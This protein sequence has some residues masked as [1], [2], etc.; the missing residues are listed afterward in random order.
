M[1]W[2]V[3]PADPDSFRPAKDPV[4]TFSER[5]RAAT[6][7]QRIEDDSW[8]DSARFSERLVDDMAR[9][10]GLSFDPKQHRNVGAKRDFLFGEIA[11]A[12][13]MSADAWPDLP[14]NTDEFNQR[15]LDLQKADH[16]A[17]QQVL[18]NA[19]AGSW[20]AEV[21]GRTWGG[22]TDASSVATLPLGAAGGARIGATILAEGAAAA[23]GEAM[24]ADQRREQA[25]RLGLPQPSVVSDVA[26]AA[27]TGAV[28]GGVIGGAG[29]LIGRGID[30][31]AAGRRKAAGDAASAES[32]GVSTEELAEARIAGLSP[33]RQEA[34]LAATRHAMENGYDIP[35]PPGPHG[36]NEAAT[37]RAIIGAESGGTRDPARA[38]NPNSSA[39]GLGQF[40]TDTWFETLSRHR[41]DLTQGKDKYQVAPL[42]DDPALNAEMTRLH[43]RDNAEHLQRNGIST[44]PGE[45]YLAHF[46]GRGGAVRAL[47]APLNTPISSLMTRREIAA[48]AGIRH[49]GK[50]FAQF[51][52]GDL[53]DWARHKMRSA[54]DPNASTDMPQWDGYT[55]SRG[56]TGSGQVTAGDNFRLDAD[57]EVVDARLLTRASG[58]YQPRDRGR[59]SSD[60]WVADTAAR[61]DP[62]QLMPAPTA[63]RGTPLVGPDGMIESG[64]GRFS[65]I[66]RAYDRHPDR[67][68]A[69][70]QQIEAA[71]YTIPEGVERPVLIAR[72]RTELDDAQRQALTV[73]AQDSGVAR[74]TPTEI[75]QTSSRAMTAQRLAGFVPTARIADPDNQGFVRQILSALPR[76]ERNALLDKAGALNAEGERR[77]R[78][79]FFARAWDDPDLVSRYAEAEDAGDL[80]S[81]MDALEDA[82]PEW[83][84]LRAEIEAGNV[85]AEFDITGHVLEAMRLIGRARSEAAAGRGQMARIL[86]DILDEIDLLDGALS[87]LTVRLV[88]KFWRDGRAAPASEVG[89]FLSRYAAEARKAGRTGDLLGISPTDALRTIDDK[90]FGDLPQEFGRVRGHPAPTV[91]DAAMPEDAYAKGADSPEAIDADQVAAEEMAAD[92][93]AARGE[94]SDMTW[95]ADPNGPEITARDLLDDIGDDI[96]LAEVLR[97]CNAGAAA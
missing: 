59:I 50:S 29:Q 6:R 64:N 87:P 43:M 39:R 13:D 91:Q 38:Q 82:A 58:P 10:M 24:I 15:A 88:Q 63:D 83:A 37:L 92:L 84:T 45:I 68:A 16:A 48:N 81:L 95:R 69:Y 7:M 96:E 67:A 71:G 27:A 75:A 66:E 14:T 18:Q 31:R 49:R 25:D 8:G 44:G 80:K 9:Q 94:Y 79:A 85:R 74:M 41:P 46:M 56:Y 26:G 1:N 36:Y 55:T 33:G 53:A 52:A 89:S 90:T 73:D 12:R 78:Q 61:L 70:R 97:L 22:L 42:R 3:K 20:G 72:R 65:A 11:R 86:A 32:L 19:P 34:A 76:S 93:E 2:F 21:L 54:Y 5:R 17:N 77:L 57:Y 23:A 28:L 60:A 35:A 30:A 4:P 47:R 51:T 40:T 62:A